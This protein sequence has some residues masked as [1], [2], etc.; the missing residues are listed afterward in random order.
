MYT[1]GFCPYCVMAKRIFDDLSVPYNE[2]RIDLDPEKRREMM[3]SA[4]GKQ[5]RKFLSAIAML[6]VV[7][8]RGTRS[9]R[10]N[11]KFG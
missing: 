7:M 10:D 5:C 1:T 9:V 2:V 4:G 3:G 6:G 8:I 11:L